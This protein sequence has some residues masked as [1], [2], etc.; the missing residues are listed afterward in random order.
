MNILIL[1]GSPRLHGNTAELCKYFMEEL[2]DNKNVIKY[3]ELEK[4]Q[5]NSCKECYICQDVNCDYGCSQKDDMIEIATNIL[6]ADVIVLATPIFSWYCTAK[7]KAVLDRHYGFNKYYG[8]AEGC[9]WEGKS[10][11]IIATHGYEGTYATEPLETG[12]K[13]LCIQSNLNYIG[14]Y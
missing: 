13:R 7:M 5:I 9:I 12:I 2:Q 4:M 10:V 6:W 3:I 1:M 14:M 8:S 11:A